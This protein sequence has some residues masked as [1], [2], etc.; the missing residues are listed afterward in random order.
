MVRQSLLTLLRWN[1]PDP[2]G[3]I[4]LASRLLASDAQDVAPAS[5]PFAIAGVLMV[6]VVVLMGWGWISSR[7]RN[8]GAA[9]IVSNVDD[10]DMELWTPHG[11]P[12]TLMLVLG[13][14]IPSLLVLGGIQCNFQATMLVITIV[15]IFLVVGKALRIFFLFSSLRKQYYRIKR[16]GDMKG[17]AYFEACLRKFEVHTVFADPDEPLARVVLVGSSQ[18]IL[19]GMYVWGLWVHGKPDFGDPRPYVYYYA[20]MFVLVAYV[21][22]KMAGDMDTSLKQ[23]AQQWR[24][25]IQGGG[26]PAQREIVNRPLTIFSSPMFWAFYFVGVDLYENDYRWASE[27]EI[28]MATLLLRSCLDTIVNTAGLFYIMVGLPIQACYNNGPVD[29]VLTA[30]AAFYILEMDDTRDLRVVEIPNFDN[31]RR[32]MHPKHDSDASANTDELFAIIQELPSD[33]CERLAAILKH[34]KL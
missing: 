14:M 8:M 27:G 15:P 23:F 12:S 20:G 18:I 13:S 32:S 2:N 21:A 10:D 3:S 28:T 33:T 1:A 31:E 19:L 24:R 16:V 6:M 26:K 30:V 7:L 4:T 34:R 22:G 9:S 17:L 11:T 5:V 29:F 25:S